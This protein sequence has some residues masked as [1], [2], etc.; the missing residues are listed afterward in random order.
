MDH[1]GWLVKS[2]ICCSGPRRRAPPEVIHHGG[3]QTR[4]AGEAEAGGSG[5]GGHLGRE[6]VGDVEQVVDR[7]AAP[8]TT[9]APTPRRSTGGG[10][11]LGTRRQGK[12]SPGSS[13]A[14]DH[15][16]QPRGRRS[17]WRRRRA[18]WGGRGT[19]GSTGGRGGPGSPSPSPR[20]A[21]RGASTGAQ[22]AKAPDREP[23]A[24]GQHGR[25]NVLDGGR[26]RQ[27]QGPGSAWSGAKCGSR[28][29]SRQA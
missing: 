26:G 27:G 9:R 5:L 25:E 10:G 18:K 23:E 29:R 6:P 24:I 12:R 4:R 19:S 3:R 22:A 21:C 14:G 15:V 11:N 7:G 13:T 1:P 17:S 8:V 28:R 2:N 20:R 16:H